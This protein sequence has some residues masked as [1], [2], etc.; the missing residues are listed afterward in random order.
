[1]SALIDCLHLSHD[2]D[3]RALIAGKAAWTYGELEA[4]VAGFAGELAARGFA[5]GSRI[6]VWAPK[7]LETV[8]AILG[9]IRAGHVAV[10]VNPVLKA[11]QVAHILADS[12]AA[13]LVADKARLNGF[14]TDVPTVELGGVAAGDAGSDA[15]ASE[16]RDPDTLAMI[17]YTSGST[18]LPKGVM[19]SHR[20]VT[21][22]AEAVT[23]YLG[24]GE[25]D[26][27][28]VP[29]PLSFDY[30]FN[31]IASALRMGACA[32]LL[33]YLLP[34]DVVKA[35]EQHGITQLP[36]V[37]PLWTQLS[38]LEWPEAARR[39]VRVLTNTGG[40]MPAHLT[41]A[42]A[43]LFPKARIFLMYG[44]T[45]AFRSA[46]LDPA[47]ALEKP[48]SVGTAIPHA[49]LFVLHPD[50][51]EAG[52]DEAGELVHCGP[53]VA[54]G[55]WQDEERTAEKFRPAPAFSKYGGR[56]VW[57]GDRMRRGADGLLY[58]E[59]RADDLI[60]VSGTRVSPTEI[61]DAA[62]ATGLVVESVAFGVADE[63]TGQ[64]VRLVAV[65]AMGDGDD[66]ALRRSISTAVPGYMVPKFIEFL[67]TL[68][69]SP[70]GKI[71]RAALKTRFADA[72]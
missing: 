60:K 23:S 9:A 54:H 27:I 14:E 45:E 4:A 50:G 67:P 6:A 3:R 42:F 34:R 29:L 25:D 16:D 58:F 13:L 72:D 28:L 39:S 17:L 63:R 52:P 12:G 53:L 15:K 1:M 62:Y 31:Q 32:V 55:Y 68:P 30:G 37:P 11:A 38:A 19:L 2:P 18:G 69:R 36:G 10:P 35:V 33:D 56:A 64:A 41:Q 44:L 8:A 71:D 46:Y 47:L 43:D 7:R 70:N 21:L 24:T 57:S 40:H 26:R 61:E 49:E 22:G 51:S 20:N 5:A 48:A 65:P 66:D 59:A